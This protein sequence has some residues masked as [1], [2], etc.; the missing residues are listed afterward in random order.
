[1]EDLLN[2]YFA[3]NF[4]EDKGDRALFSLNRTYARGLEN[5]KPTNAMELKKA[6]KCIMANKLQPG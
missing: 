5:K 1:M 4:P 3:P 2:S 6:S